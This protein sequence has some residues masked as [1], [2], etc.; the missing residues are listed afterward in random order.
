[1]NVLLDTSILPTRPR[2]IAMERTRFLRISSLIQKCNSRLHSRL[3]TRLPAGPLRPEVVSAPTP[4]DHDAKQVQV[5][6]LC[7]AQS[8]CPT[9]GNSHEGTC[10]QRRLPGTRIPPLVTDAHT[11]RELTVDH[12]ACV[13]V[14]IFVDDAPPLNS[15]APETPTLLF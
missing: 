11:A 8:M 1:M 15:L 2:A 3:H 7:L 13:P 10:H 4:R 5:P 9:L 6:L 14:L 12:S